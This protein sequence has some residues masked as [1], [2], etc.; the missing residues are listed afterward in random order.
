MHAGQCLAKALAVYTRRKE[1][2]VIGLPRGGVPVA[3]EVAKALR[4]PLDLVVVRKLGVPGCEELAMGALAAGGVR[5]INDEVVRDFG[6]SHQAIE[7]AVKRELVELHRREIA[8]R[9]HATPPPVRGKTVILVDD[10]IATGST[11]RAAARALQQLSPARIVI[12][13]PV[14]ASDTCAALRALV[15][16]VIVLVRPEELRAVG[17]WYDNFEQTSDEEV[18]HLL[19]QSA[20]PATAPVTSQP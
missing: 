10:G 13:A 19:A 4:A 16:D 15:D 20:P 5:V 2:I 1:V 14:G 6:I 17:L 8:Y 18:M 7:A 9:G 11:I 12:A 3:Y